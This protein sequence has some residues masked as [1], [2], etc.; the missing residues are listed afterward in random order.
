VTKNALLSAR[1]NA[2]RTKMTQTPRF[3][4]AEWRKNYEVY[5]DARNALETAEIIDLIEGDLT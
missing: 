2:A 4:D 5:L 3:P 1:L